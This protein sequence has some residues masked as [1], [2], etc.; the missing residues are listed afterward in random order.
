VLQMARRSSR[1]AGTGTLVTAAAVDARV[2]RTR[3]D[4]CRATLNVLIDEG[5]DA[6][7][8]PH[9]AAV[10]GYSR[11]TVYKHWPT[12]ADLLRDALARLGD[13]V[14]HHTP[15]GELRADLIQELTVFRWGMQHRRLDRALA[16]VSDLTASVPELA[17]LRDKLVGEGEQ[18]VRSLLAPVLHGPELEAVTLMLCGSVLQSAFMHGQL[19]SD[20]VISATVDVVLRGLDPR[21][22][23]ERSRG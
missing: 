15:V 13:E 21:G 22:R 6:V 23:A 12:K 9:I 11:A 18:A 19:P 8:Q 14:G 3:N 10:A 20:E 16:V 17:E 7:T 1:Q 5:R 2:V 4:I